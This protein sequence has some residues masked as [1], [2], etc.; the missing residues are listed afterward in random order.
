M[1]LK[2]SFALL[3]ILTG[4]TACSNDSEFTS[5]T[6][7]GESKAEEQAKAEDASG[8]DLDALGSEAPIRCRCRQPL[9][10]PTLRRHPM[11]VKTQLNAGGSPWVESVGR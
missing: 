6:K 7:S 4:L 5:R 9:N 11:S 3:S 1:K 2:L 8:T 10:G